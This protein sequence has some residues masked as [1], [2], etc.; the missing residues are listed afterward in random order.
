MYFYL[1]LLFSVTAGKT[2][3]HFIVFFFLAFPLSLC[4]SLSVSC[5]ILAVTY[6]SIKLASKRS[7]TFALLAVLP[8]SYFAWL[9]RFC[10]LQWFIL[11]NN[12]FLFYFN[13]ISLNKFSLKICHEMKSALFLVFCLSLD[14][15]LLAILL[16]IASSLQIQFVLIENPCRLIAR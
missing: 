16:L 5:S 13:S 9:F 4:L 3:F 8:L 15:I 2:K 12:I 14:S 6:S 10:F 11:F 1:S 7:A